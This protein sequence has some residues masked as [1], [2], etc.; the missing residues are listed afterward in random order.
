MKEAIAL[1]ALLALGAADARPVYSGLPPFRFM[2]DGAAFTIYT[3]NVEAFC[4]PPT[5]GHVILAC[6]KKRKGGIPVMVLPN[7]CLFPEERFATLACHEKA[8]VAGWAG[9]HPY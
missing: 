8:H 3:V 6:A 1:A 2:G 9:D 4:G 7:P 5:P